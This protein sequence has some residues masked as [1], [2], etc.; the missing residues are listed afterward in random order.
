MTR[1]RQAAAASCSRDLPPDGHRPGGVCR[2]LGAQPPR[3]RREAIDPWSFTAV[4][5]GTGAL[6][7]VALT[8]KRRRKRGNA[9]SNK[10]S[11]RAAGAA[12]EG[13]DLVGAGGTRSG[14]AKVVA[15]DGRAGWTRAGYLVLYALPFSLAY[16]ELD[17]GTGALLLFGAVQLTMLTLGIRAGER[18]A[19]L[20]WLALAG[21][22][23]GMAYFVSPGVTAPDPLGAALMV[24]AGLFALMNRNR[25]VPV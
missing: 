16:V 24:A 21:A 22:A 18:P 2:Q 17:T 14:D 11:S 4:R 3:A 7:L 19:V 8:A 9:G 15:I 13:T 6:V 20:E 1:W 10:R 23:G 5:L 25:T 12:A